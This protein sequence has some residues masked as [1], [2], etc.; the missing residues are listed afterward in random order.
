M[1][2]YP[3]LMYVSDD[4]DFHHVYT[5]KR[6]VIKEKDGCYIAYNGV[7]SFERL[8]GFISTPDTVTWQYAKDIET[9]TYPIF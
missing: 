8:S 3:K 5:F 9:Q 1:S 4:P 7:D 2:N 6:I